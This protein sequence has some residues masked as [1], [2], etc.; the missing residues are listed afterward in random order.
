MCNIL[1]KTFV[2]LNKSKNIIMVDVKKLMTISNYALK[3]KK[4]RS[5]VITLIEKGK[6]KCVEIDG[7]K[8]IQIED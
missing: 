4:S 5:W 3:I 8:F 6:I 1:H 7:F 2:Y